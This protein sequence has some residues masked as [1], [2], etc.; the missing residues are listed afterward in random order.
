MKP[1][2]PQPM[3][4]RTGCEAQADQL[5]VRDHP[6]LPAGQDG[7]PRVTLFT[8]PFHNEGKVKSVVFSP[9]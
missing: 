1:A 3:L 2:C 4:N 6:M 5:P 8:F 7:H 9:P